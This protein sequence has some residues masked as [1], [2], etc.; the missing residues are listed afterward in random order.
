LI[1]LALLTLIA[2]SPL[3][4]ASG[5]KPDFNR[6]IRPIL[7]D[8]CFACH[9][10][11]E[12]KRVAGIRLDTAEGARAALVPGQPDKS[13]AYLRMSH[14][15][16][17]RRMPPPSSGRQL[18]EQQIALVKRWIEAG[19][20]Y[21]VHWAYEAPRR[22]EPPPVKNVRWSRNAI[23]RF[24]LARLEKEGLNPSPE[25]DRVTVLRRLSFDLTGL[26]PTPAEI[27]VFL[28]DRS[29][30]AYDKQVDRLLASPHYGERMAMQWL[31][32]ARYADTHGFHIDSHRDMWPWRD[33]VIR[34]FNGNLPFD[35][36]TIEQ[37][38]GDLFPNAGIDQKIASGFNRN[39]MINY[40]GGAI[41]E[42]YRTEYV[43]DRVET[44]STVWLGMT[45]GCA[46]CH[47]HKYD[48]IPQKDFYRMFAF[49]NNVKEKG[50]DGKD[51]NAEPFLSLPTVEQKRRLDDLTVRIKTRESELTDAQVKPHF[52]AWQ[53]EQKIAW[54]RADLIA[55]YEMDGGVTDSSGNYRHGRAVRGEV[56][57]VAA[58]VGRAMAFTTPS[59][60][61]FDGVR[62][63]ETFTIATWL[64]QGH[65]EPQIVFQ[66][67]GR[68]SVWY[69]ASEPLPHLRRG[70]HLHVQAAGRHV[71]TRERLV[72][73]EMYHVAIGVAGGEISVHVNGL[74]AGLVVE[75][76][77][78]AA[79][80]E[81]FAIGA[82][83]DSDERNG[84]R[85]RLADLRLYDR[86]V[87]AGELKQ[88]AVHGRVGALLSIAPDKRTREQ[89]Q[90]LRSY[91]LA[92]A[93]PESLRTAW[94]DLQE[95]KSAK[96]KLDDE[97]PNTMVMVERDEP[98]ETFI[99]GRGDYRHRGDKVTAGTPSALPPLPQGA[100]AD[101]MALA[102][103]LVDPANPL[104][105]RV[106]VNR[107]WQNLFGT[108]LVKTVENF[109]SQ[110]E[111][112]SHPELLDWLAVEFVRSGW[113]MKA[114]HRLMVTSA[115]YRQTSKAT[116]ELI[117][118][119][120]E[121]RLLA[122]M[123]RFRLPAEMVRDSAL[124]SSGLLRTT[125][126]GPS[127]YP[128]QPE[129]IWEEIA[130]G[131]IFSAQV[132]KP[133]EGD[134]LYRR[135]MY[136]FWKRTAP[137]TSLTTFDAPDREKCTAR[138]SLTNTPLQALVL[139]NDPT[140]V[141]AARVLA[142][143]SLSETDTTRRIEYVFRSVLGR[144]PRTDEAKLLAGLAARQ[145]ARYSSD[146]EAARQLLSVGDAKP[147]Q[148][149][150]HAELAAWTNVAA[151]VMNTDEAITK[152]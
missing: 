114:L 131:E 13:R 110:G 56:S 130:R 65:H 113:D 12:Q 149:V 20:E 67:A 3:S 69:D 49:F 55:H 82:A 37:I 109:G 68:F 59:Y 78:A 15:D 36:F 8:N 87:N 134:G 142:E 62:L 141:E 80:S 47:D 83:A 93:A 97:I 17:R 27:D 6:E 34:A 145:I 79:E 86:R 22:S 24:I 64:Q 116:P 35:R 38:A 107:F 21:D 94:L 73:G 144:K 128:Y 40:E 151:A 99:L 92:N 81:C 125:I 126:G 147:R 7:S 119:D 43:A 61:T 60:V 121:N 9:G 71:R 101:R 41:E 102:R 152:E 25:A 74:A 96:A 117:E 26:P 124:A 88:L 29:P 129:G 122:R 105:A 50:L 44:T 98:R 66:Q 104:T 42:E 135:S 140:F 32:L 132:Y 118:R 70:A 4:A 45:M 51:G 5:A 148:A 95:L 106:T 143:R 57:G 39:H 115:A 138:R 75:P 77:G 31:D 123:S 23:D 100:K 72:Q 91:Y 11:D 48:P 103:W 136:W 84:F 108:G 10:P 76:N 139:L 19:A 137:P 16:P 85:G 90:T 33:W 120:P 111:P 18:T 1:R 2:L 53:K 54:E 133:S 146:I 58:T 28:N 46:R 63:P 14:A 150:S 30:R 52:E 89:T 112:P 127:V